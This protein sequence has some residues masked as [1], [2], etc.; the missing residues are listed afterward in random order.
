MIHFLERC[1]HSFATP[2]VNCDRKRTGW[3]NFFEF[4]PRGSSKSE[5]HCE[6]L[7]SKDEF[8]PLFDKV[9]AAGIPGRPGISFA[10]TTDGDD[11]KADFLAADPR[12]LFAA[13]V[14]LRLGGAA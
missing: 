7:C 6:I 11:W 14:A 9:R 12:E 3:I 8:L 1:L 10:V 4:T 13:F 2:C 5:L